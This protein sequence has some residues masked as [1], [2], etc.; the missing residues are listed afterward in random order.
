M[1][2]G[3]LALGLEGI[4]AKNAASPYIEGPRVP[5]HWLKIKNQEYK[6]EKSVEFRQRKPPRLR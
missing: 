2:A 3:A 6:R 4:V 5:G 1:L